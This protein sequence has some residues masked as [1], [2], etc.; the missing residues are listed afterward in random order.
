MRDEKREAVSECGKHLL[1]LSQSVRDLSDLI[2]R[3]TEAVWSGDAA[4]ACR[5]ETQDCAQRMEEAVGTFSRL[6][7]ESWPQIS[8]LSESEADSDKPDLTQN[9]EWII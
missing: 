9:A 3:R 7:C 1:K 8:T 4:D 2:N 5:L 6:L